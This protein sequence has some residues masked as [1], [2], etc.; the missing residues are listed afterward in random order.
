MEERQFGE[1]YLNLTG[2][3]KIYD[4]NVDFYI[5]STKFQEKGIRKYVNFNQGSVSRQ[6]CFDA[7]VYAKENPSGKAEN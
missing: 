6:R 3:A 5:L 7:C 1:S 2:S 4:K